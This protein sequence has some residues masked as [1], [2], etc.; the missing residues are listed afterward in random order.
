MRM[1]KFINSFAYAIDGIKVCL[2]QRNLRIHITVAVLVVIVGFWLK[3]S[4]A[5]WAVLVLTMGLVISLELVN[6]AIE[7]LVDLATS[8]YHILAKTAKDV[9][10]GAVLVSAIASVFI[11]LLIFIPP[12]FRLISTWFSVK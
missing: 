6:T 10:A 1:K 12:L 2:K 4:I 8:E 3:I 11:G 9:A 7:S 5:E